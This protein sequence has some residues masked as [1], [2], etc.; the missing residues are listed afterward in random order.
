VPLLWPLVPFVEFPFMMGNCE[1]G[2]CSI[3]LVICEWVSEVHE[4]LSYINLHQAL[5]Y[6]N[7]VLALIMYRASMLDDA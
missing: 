7:F 4:E 3:K 1:M 6:T 2:I 5:L